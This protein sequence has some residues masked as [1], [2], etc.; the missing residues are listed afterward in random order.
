MEVP[1]HIAMNT[2]FIESEFD[3]RITSFSSFLVQ[4]L[5]YNIVLNMRSA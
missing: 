3:L 2:I 4:W 5:F 1:K